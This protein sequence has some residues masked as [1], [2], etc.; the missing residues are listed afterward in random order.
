MVYSHVS[1][2]YNISFVEKNIEPQAKALE[3]VIK[4]E[5]SPIGDNNAGMQQIQSWLINLNL[6]IHDMKKSKEVT[7]KVWC[8]KCKV[9][10]HYK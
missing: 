8:T 3:L 7:E 2:T 6:H 9:E 4:L 10:G 1:S 5:A